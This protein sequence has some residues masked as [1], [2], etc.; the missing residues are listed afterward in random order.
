MTSADAQAVRRV[1]APQRAERG[2]VVGKRLALAHEHHRG[3]TA[4]KVVAHVHDLA[5][6]LA[7]GKR[8]REARGARS[9]EG[10]AHAAACLRGGA[11]GQ[12]RPGGHAHAL[13]RGAVGKFQ[14]VLT[15]AVLALL[16]REL[17][18]ATQAET[19]GQRSAQRLGEVA[20]LVKR[21]GAL[22]PKPFLNLLCPEL[23]LAQLF[24]CGKQLA[25]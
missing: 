15:A 4:S 1:K 19:L 22:L 20:H 11:D 16:A 13:N 18:H 14:Q 8:A 12:A 3:D 25:V 21:G 2:V 23:G 5:I 17:L 24:E 10:A 6:D 7:G 9:A